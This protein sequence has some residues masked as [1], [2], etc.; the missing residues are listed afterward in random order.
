[1][2]QKIR[3]NGATLA[4]DMAVF[5]LKIRTPNHGAIEINGPMFEPATFTLWAA[6]GMMCGKTGPKYLPKI[7]DT[8]ARKAFRAAL[9]RL[10][11]AGEALAMEIEEERD[12]EKLAAELERKTIK[13]KR[14]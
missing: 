6:V 3:L 11:A 10:A 8:P 12:F 2:S 13:V 5:A 9:K 1:M 7:D 14:K 4:P